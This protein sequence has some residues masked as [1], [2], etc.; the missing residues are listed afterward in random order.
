MSTKLEQ[1]TVLMETLALIFVVAFLHSV[2]Q[3]ENVLPGLPLTTAV[4][5]PL[6]GLRY[7]TEVIAVESEPRM[8]RFGSQTRFQLLEARCFLEAPSLAVLLDLP[9]MGNT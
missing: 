3:I 6:K 7:S 8:L 4:Q 5:S 2:S 9:Q 1:A